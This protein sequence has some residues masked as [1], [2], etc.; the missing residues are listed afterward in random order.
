MDTAAEHVVTARD[1]VYSFSSGPA[2]VSI[3][4]LFTGVE[5]YDNVFMH[6][7]VPYLA[8]AFY[9]GSK[10]FFAGLVSR[11][12][13]TGTS[14]GF[15]ALALLHNVLLATYSLWTA[16]NVVPLTFAHIQAHGALDAYCGN[17]LWEDSLDGTKGLGFW[18]FWFY[19]SKIYEIGDTY[20]LIAKRRKPSYLQVYHHAST[21]LCAYWLTASHAT[22][23]FLFVGLNS[24]VHSIMYT[25]FALATVGVRLP[26]K[27][28]ITS[29]QIAQFVFGICAALPTFVL[30]NGTC[31]NDAQK[32]AVAGIILSVLKLIVL[33]SAFYSRTYSKKT[34]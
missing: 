27:S 7:A 14:V 22:V 31:S 10:P 34:A 9:L 18:A 17:S 2:A 13:I 28:M 21:I 12:G 29:V 20:V 5:P 33:F 19:V 11:M 32:F 24:T 6:P 4:D 23:N 1:A 15:R 16:V 25:Y 26:G 30:Q 8:I 3:A